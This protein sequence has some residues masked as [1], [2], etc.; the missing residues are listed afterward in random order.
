MYFSG[1]ANSSA[2]S[3]KPN[4]QLPGSH[5]VSASTPSISGRESNELNFFTS[6]VQ[7]KTH[8]ISRDLGAGFSRLYDSP[9]II[10]LLF[11]SIFYL[12]SQFYMRFIFLTHSFFD[13]RDDHFFVFHFNISS[14]FYL[15]IQINFKINS[16]YPWGKRI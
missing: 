1:G 16:V 14:F 7:P 2:N 8:C 12:F 5:R 10:F 6:I 11:L 3:G 15:F 4:Y 9:S 13:S